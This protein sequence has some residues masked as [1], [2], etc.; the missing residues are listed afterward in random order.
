MT[1][2]ERAMQI[3]QVLLGLAYNRQTITYETLAELIG[4]GNISVALTQPLEL[5]MNYCKENDLPPITILVVQKHSGIPGQGLTTIEE[6]NKDREK[7]F[8]YEWFKLKPLSL[9]D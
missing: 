1:R 2:P 8:N 6:L 9:N 3:W 7:V 5:L 4:M